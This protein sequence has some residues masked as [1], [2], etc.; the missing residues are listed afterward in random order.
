MDFRLVQ[1]D[2][3]AWRRGTKGN[4]LAALSDGR[5]VVVQTPMC[6]CRV[7]VHKPGM[8]RCDMTLCRRLDVHAEFADWLGEVEAHAGGR[9][10]EGKSL[11]GTL[12]AD[13]FRLMLFS[14][15]LVFDE[16]GSLSAEAMTARK[17]SAILELT[18]AWTREARWGLQWKVVQLKFSTTAM[19]LPPE[20]ASSDDSDDGEGFGFVDD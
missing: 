7:T 14:D 13:N 1:P 12:Y 20:F 15:T 3:I 9:W 11:S 4:A 19:D 8:F 18:G 2:A 10:S 16:G 5:R 17:A 6:P